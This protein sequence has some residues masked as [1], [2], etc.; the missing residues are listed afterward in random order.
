MDEFSVSCRPPAPSVV[1]VGLPVPLHAFFTFSRHFFV[2]YT[3]ES[4]SKGRPGPGNF[5]LKH[6]R[7]NFLPQ[8]ELQHSSM[9]SPIP[10]ILQPLME[11]D[12]P[13]V[14]GWATA[15]QVPALLSAA[16]SIFGSI[17]INLGRWKAVDDSVVKFSR[18]TLF[19]GSQLWNQIRTFRQCL[20]VTW[21]DMAHS[22]WLLA[23]LTKRK[24]LI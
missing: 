22:D 17:S 7:C 21:R 15:T 19:W 9:G 5:F 2:Q 23:T 13:P 8:A 11:Q 24:V 20:G 14:A 6:A 10:A 18:E 3:S 4:W 16:A 12:G 1:Q